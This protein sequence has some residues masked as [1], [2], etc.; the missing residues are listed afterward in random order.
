[1]NR[2][3][4]NN[5]LHSLVGTLL[6]A[7]TGFGSMLVLIRTQTPNDFGQW[8]LYLTLYGLV[9]M[10]RSGLIQ[11]GLIKF[12]A[13]TKAL[14]YTGAALTMSVVF[15]FL[16]VL[17]IVVVG[18][19]IVL[20]PL[21]LWQLPFLLIAT[22][23]YSLLLWQWQAENRFVALMW[24]RLAYSVP[25]LLLL[26]T[27]FW[28]SLSVG[29]IAISQSVIYLLVSVIAFEKRFF[30]GIKTMSL[31]HLK[32]LWHFGK[33][34]IGTLLGTNLLKSSDTFLIGFFLNTTAVAL[35][36]FPY[37]LIEI[38]EIPLR[39]QVATLLPQWVNL[40]K[41]ETITQVKKMAL[42]LTL[43]LLPVSAGCFLFSQLILTTLGGTAYQNSVPL[44]Q[45]FAIYSL[46][47]P[48]DRLLG[49]ALDAIGKPQLNTIKVFIMLTV[50]VLGDVLVLK[51]G[52]ELWQVA[53]ITIATIIVGVS[54]GLFFLNQQ[55]D[56]FMNFNQDTHATSSPVLPLVSIITINYDQPKVTAQLLTSLRKITYPNVE[57]FVVDN[58]SPKHSTDAIMG[59]F[60]EV[61]FIKSSV[62]LGFAGGN[63]LAVKQAKGDYLLFINN[64]VE[65]A[66]TFLESLVSCL[67][68]DS[69]IGMAS[70]KIK[71]FDAPTTLQ[72]AGCT[73]INLMTGQGHFIGHHQ[74]DQLAFAQTQPTAYIHGAAMLVSRKVLEQT[75]LMDDDYFLYYE[76]LDWCA[77]A[78]RDGFGVWYVADSEV[79]HKESM[80]TGKESPLKVY[81]QTRNR[82]K[83]LQK[84][85]QLW[86]QIIGIG[87]ILGLAVPKNT[88]TYLLKKRYDLA[89]ASLM[90]AVDYLL[91]RNAF[92]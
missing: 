42:R 40:S 80:S 91:N 22:I 43:W 21:I 31:A 67:Q 4:K 78:K 62:N 35:Y 46:F 55:K 77:R 5:A 79:W 19:F 7:L 33:F 8:T 9:D 32:N 72:Y 56:I 29:Q 17:L 45:A 38:I 51:G 13:D 57:I 66:P 73:E 65:V 41:N 16:V 11:T 89:K 36:Q 54:A 60:P 63:N 34:S 86:Q 14:A 23:P 59:A 27:G 71:Y 49:I 1:M 85:G 26:V 6:V 20:S 39:S 12:W 53:A 48:L 74:E 83:F 64:D 61:N 70:P 58:N 69:S 18:F 76:E 3:L 75:G 25:F 88:L 47:L 90:G 82:L 24:V 84:N 52:G 44:L 15:T 28:F 68:S 50:N 2:F 81:F 87:F 10:M 92:A 30:E 37:K